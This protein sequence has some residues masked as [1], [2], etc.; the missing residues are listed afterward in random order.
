MFTKTVELMEKH[1]LL[2]CYLVTEDNRV[3]EYFEERLGEKLLYID[4]QRYGKCQKEDDWIW[5]RKV[6]RENHKYLSGLEYLMEMYL[7]TFC[8][9]LCGGVTGGMIGLSLLDDWNYKE[10]F[11]WDLGRF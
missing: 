11:F 2:Y 8:D 5:M 7:L 6:D 3:L 10:M 9:V 1:N 4:A